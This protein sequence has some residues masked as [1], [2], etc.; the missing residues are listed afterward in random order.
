MRYFVMEFAVRRA[1][2]G[3]QLLERGG[4][5]GRGARPSGIAVQ[6]A[7]AL[8]HADEAG[9]VHRDVKPDN[10]LVTK[11]GTAKLCDLGLAKDRPG[12]GSPSLGTPNYISPE[13]ARS[14][15]EVDIRADLY[16]LGAT[17]YHMLT[18][19]TPFEGNAKVVMVKHLSEEPKSILAPAG[20]R[21][22]RSD[23]EKRSSRKLMQ[24][25]PQRAAGARPG[26][27]HEAMFEATTSAYLREAPRRKK[28]AAPGLQRRQKPR[29]PKEVAV[30]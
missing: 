2:I 16:S 7:R 28:S 8:E 5:H 17:L 23:I 26:T 27:S 3:K 22:L 21:H 24:E 25:E 18:G 9:L 1:A 30:S 11:N 6:I 29:R 14:G 20:A 10:I 12:E 13:Q 19:R 15:R 4:P